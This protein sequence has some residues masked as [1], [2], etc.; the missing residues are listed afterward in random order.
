MARKARLYADVLSTKDPEYYKYEGLSIKWNSPEN[1]EI[2]KKI[3]HGKYSEVFEG[4]D[5]TNN[6]NVVIKVLKPVKKEKYKREVKILMNLSGGTNVIKLLNTVK[7]PITKCPALIFEYVNNSHFRILY[8]SL[9]DFQVRYYIYELLKALDYSH[10][11]GIMHRDVKPQN[12][13]IDHSNRLLRLIDWGLAEFYHPGTDYNVR[14][15][16]RY[17]KGPELLVDDELYNYSLDMWSLG[18]MLAGIIFQKDPFFHGRDNQD[19]LVKIAKI[20]GTQELYRYLAKYSIE[21]SSVLEKMVGKHVQKPWQ[22][23]ITHENQHLVVPEAL[24]FL[25]LL[26]K[27]DHNERI[28]P[29]EAMKHPYFAPVVHMWADLEAGRLPTNTQQLETAL[30]IKSRLKA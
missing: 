20:L 29:S 22:R 3:G 28:L 23:F 6:Q 10:S 5:I 18:A 17:F 26:L 2:I 16:S 25:G 13:M 4:V 7:D 24:D 1:Y 19:Q 14:V 11:M 30:I 27:Y 8:P 12:V 9:T 21:M 15:A